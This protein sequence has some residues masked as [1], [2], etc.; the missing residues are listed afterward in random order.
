MPSA[1]E[2]NVLRRTVLP[3]TSPFRREKSTAR[4][5]SP[6]QHGRPPGFCRC[7]YV[8]LEQSD[9]TNSTEA[10]K[11]I[12]VRTKALTKMTNYT[13]RAKKVEGHD[14]KNSGAGHVPVPQLQKFIPAPRH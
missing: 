3:E 5:T 9:D 13:R 10:A 11:D 4:T 1:T 2:A 12:F 14:R 7:W 8:R 6:I